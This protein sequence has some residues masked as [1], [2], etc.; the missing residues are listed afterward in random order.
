MIRALLAALS[1]FVAPAAA[2]ECRQALALG[3]DVSGSVDDTEYRLQLDGLAHAIDH[4]E[5]RAALFAMPSAPVRLAVYEW[6]GQGS[7][8]IL[9][10]W[11]PV[12]SPDALDRIIATLRMTQRRP[13]RL[14]TALM[15]AQRF[16]AALLAEQAECWKRTLDISGDGKSNEGPAPYLVDRA[17]FLQGIT[18]NGLVIGSDNPAPGDQRAVQ[19]AELLAYFEAY[20]LFGPDAF[21][22]TALG[23]PE[24][25]E[26]MVRKLKRE[27][28]GVALSRL[29][30]PDQ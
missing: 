29:A 15:D 6:A 16:G 8:R 19:I 25:Q 23:Y 20:V 22:E 26:A 18:V 28:E 12:E 9:L 11:T 2:Q 3:L 24:F 7:E 10:P 5:I 1:V 4:P 14:S 27:L 13:T 17:A 21:A 30:R